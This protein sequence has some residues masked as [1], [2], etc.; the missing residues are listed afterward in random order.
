MTQLHPV[1]V[2][3]LDKDYHI[4]CPAAERAN[5]ESA[6]RFLD[7]KMREI[8]DGGK[9]LG[10]E[11]IAVL[12]A[13]NISYEMLQGQP[14]N[15]GTERAPRAEA[16]ELLERI[17]QEL[18]GSDPAMQRRQQ[19]ATP[20]QGIQAAVR[21]QPPVQP[22]QV[23]QPP[24]QQP[25]IQQAQAPQPQIQ[26]PVEAPS[27]PQQDNS[28]YW[29]PPVQQQVQQ[30]DP[31]QDP[32]PQNPQPAWQGGNVA[33]QDNWPGEQNQGWNGGQNQ[34]QQ[35]VAQPQEGQPHGGQ[36]FPGNQG[37]G[38]GNQQPGYWNGNAPYTN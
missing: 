37:T 29:Q 6:A 13:L 12:A 25:Q 11:R 30:P 16:G 7:G 1:T 17:D 2:N 31:W 21:S 28:Q 27:C 15:G 3:I 18:H 26:P 33:P 34:Y 35:P 5:L 20:R 19:T 24:I 22:S 10:A 9:V 36:S 32:Q 4:R 23:Q 38:N 14:G 8:R